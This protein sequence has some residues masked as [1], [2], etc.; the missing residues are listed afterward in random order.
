MLWG[1]AQESDA[2]IDTVDGTLAVAVWQV[3]RIARIVDYITTRPHHQY[4]FQYILGTPTRIVAASR[5]VSYAA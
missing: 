4:G 1:D 3:Q 2:G 5:T